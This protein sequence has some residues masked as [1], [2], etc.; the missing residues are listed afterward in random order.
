[1]PQKAKVHF[2][3]RERENRLYI[4]GKLCPLN[5]SKYII[6]NSKRE[7]NKEYIG[8]FK[9]V[10]DCRQKKF[11]KRMSIKIC[12]RAIMISELGCLLPGI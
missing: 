5:N 3:Q 1:M 12:N 4:L 8:P 9:I 10:A 2:S 7:R 6:V 11:L